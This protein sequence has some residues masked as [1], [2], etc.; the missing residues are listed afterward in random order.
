MCLLKQVLEILKRD[1]PEQ[2]QHLRDALRGND[3][4]RL[5][6][7]AHK[8]HGVTCYASLPRLRRLVVAFQQTLATGSGDALTQAVDE[9]DDE[10]ATVEKEVVRHLQ[11]YIQA[12]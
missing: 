2:R 8:L 3:L 7:L 4:D 5:G 9:L 1:I 12:V 10:L 6:A 11:K